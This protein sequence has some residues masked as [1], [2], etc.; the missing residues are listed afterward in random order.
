MLYVNPTLFWPCILTVQKID[1]SSSPEVIEESFPMQWSRN[2]L[3]MV[4]TLRAMCVLPQ[5]FPAAAVWPSSLESRIQ[6][7]G[8]IQVI[9]T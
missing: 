7:S 2:V 6:V 5:G 8:I 3:S 1:L 4:F 9:C